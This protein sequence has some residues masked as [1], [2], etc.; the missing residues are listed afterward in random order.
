MPVTGMDGFLWI[1]RTGK[2]RTTHQAYTGR[3]NTGPYGV[4]QGEEVLVPL[5]GA[6]ASGL[7]ENFPDDAELLLNAAA[8]W[9]I[10]W[11]CPDKALAGFEVAAAK[12]SAIAAYNA[13]LMRLERKQAGDADKALELFE[14]GAA[15][16]DEPSVAQAAKLRAVIQ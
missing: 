8:G 11:H 7:E 13:A 6:W 4:K 9:D 5:A 14:R 16:G 1:D 3:F 2:M 12:G 15:L 10:F